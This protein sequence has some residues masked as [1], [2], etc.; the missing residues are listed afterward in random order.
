MKAL[1]LTE[2]RRLELTEMAAPE[3]GPDDVLVR[4]RACGIC[5]SDIHGF[6]GSTGRRVPP[7]VM[8]HEAAGTVAEVGSSVTGLREGDRVTFDSTV[9]C[10]ECHFCRRGQVN[11]CDRRRVL[12]VSCGDYRQHGAFAE[13][14]VVPQRIIYRLP[15][16]LRFEE[17]AM[18]EPVSVVFH[19]LSL[20][21]MTLGCTAVVVGT[22]MIGLLVVQA[23]RLAGAGRVFA[24]DVDEGKLELAKSLGADEGFNPKEADVPALIAARTEGRGADVAVEAVGASAPIQTAIACL[25]KG[26]A[27]TLVGNLTPRIEVPLQSIV[28]RE[29]KLT[30]SCGSSGEYPACIEMMARGDIKVAPLISRTAPLEEGAAWFER[31]YGREQ[32]LMKVILNP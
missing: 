17:A 21:P 25:R 1:L 9:S 30:G 32:G 16:S 4:V 6:D 24:V 2:Y 26:G 12:G 23:L 29:L 5:G 15:D 20:T 31:L 19:A 27:L 13:Y 8:G 7:L 28:T 14:V 10:G 11:L 18:I 22:G 3:V